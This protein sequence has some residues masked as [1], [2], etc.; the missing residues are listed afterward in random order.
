[1]SER[2]ILL[3]AGGT[4]GH[5]FPAEALATELARRGVA[6]ELITDERALAY[7]KHFPARA[8]HATPADTIRGSG[9]AAYAKLG[10]TLARGVARSAGILRRVR[11]A[12]VVGFGGYPTFPPLAAAKLVGAPVVLHEQNAVM[13]RANRMLAKFATAIATGFPTVSGLPEG[14]RPVHVGNPVRPQVLAASRV[15]YQAPVGEQPV[16]LLIFGGSQGARVMSEVAPLAIARLPV[17]LRS[18]IRVTQQARPEDIEN[19]RRAYAEAGVEAALATFF[20]D[21]PARMALAHFVIARAGASTVAE[22][23][24]IGRPSIL[25]PLPHALD[26]DQLANAN[27]LAMAGG[28]VVTAQSRFTPDALADELSVRLNDPDAL[29]ASAAAARQV[30][31][32][33]AAARLADVVLATARLGSAAPA[34]SASPAS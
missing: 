23:S 10:L 22:L 11:P 30:G 9:V 14:A 26:N 34:V 5:L 31:K 16:R 21:M 28:A 4:G 25:V 2:P 33:D 13:G 12:A 15:A 24:V 17:E 3:A 18:R 27:A 20:D 7:A 1:M 8:L 19:V 29:A 6:V 32:P